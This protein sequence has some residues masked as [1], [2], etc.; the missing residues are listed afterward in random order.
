MNIKIAIADDHSL[1]AEGVSN[2]LRYSSELEVVATYPNGAALLS[3]LEKILPDVL[4]LD[5]NMPDKQGDELAPVIKNNY[6]TIKIIALTSFDNIF[7]IKSMLQH[8]IEGYLLKHVSKETLI[9]AVKVVYSGG[10]FID[11]AVTKLLQQDEEIT[12]RQKEMGTALTKREK[13]IL[14]LLAGSHTSAEIA[15]MLFLSKRTV[16]HHRESIMTK[17]EVKKL[18]ALVKKANEMGLLG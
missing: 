8:D 14:Q 5:I 15:E 4:L 10:R 7:Y 17:L 11:E 18:S 6:P 1:I 16:E 9:D 12:R 3:G 13:E 2:M